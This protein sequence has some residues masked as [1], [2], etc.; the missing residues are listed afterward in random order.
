MP[1]RKVSM[2]ASMAN[3][4]SHLGIMGGLAKGRTAGASGNRATNK[5]VIPRGAAKGLAYMQLHGILSRNPQTGGVGKVVKSKPCNCKGLGKTKVEGDIGETTVEGDEYGRAYYLFKQGKCGDTSNYS[6]V[7]VFPNNFAGA[8]TYCSQHSCQAIEGVQNSTPGGAGYDYIAKKTIAHL[9]TKVPEQQCIVVALPDPQFPGSVVGDNS[10]AFPPTATAKPT[11]S[12]EK[13]CPSKNYYTSTTTACGG[14]E[15]G[16]ESY[17]N[18][19]KAA[20]LC[21]LKPCQAIEGIKSAGVWS[22]TPYRTISHLDINSPTKT[23]YVAQR[24]SP[25]Y[26]GTVNADELESTTARTMGTK[27]SDYDLTTPQKSLPNV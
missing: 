7:Q 25:A 16:F 8:V 9:D 22:Y 5:L 20:D 14:A 26:P 23:C 19:A 4:T 3:Q 1:S 11:T 10:G 17:D 27:I 24:P 2:R 15:G 21:N 18:F 6:D 13:W 12:C